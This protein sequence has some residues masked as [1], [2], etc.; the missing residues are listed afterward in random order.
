AEAGR[1][2]GRRAVSDYLRAGQLGDFVGRIAERSEDLVVVVAK[3]GRVGQRHASPAEVDWEA[4]KP[5][6]PGIRLVQ[7]DDEP[8]LG[9]VLVLDQ[10][11]VGEGGARRHARVL[12]YGRGVERRPP[13]RPGR[14]RRVDRLA[15]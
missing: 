15:L 12:E 9:E 1:R 14:D 8:A 13:S 6:R 2:H 10:I 4:R 5:L 3:P 7:G 11:A